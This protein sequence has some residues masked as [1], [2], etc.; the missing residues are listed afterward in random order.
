MAEVTARTFPWLG[1]EV[2]LVLIRPVAGF[3]L[4]S[5]CI[6]GH[7]DVRSLS[8]SHSSLSAA[9]GPHDGSVVL[10]ANLTPARHLTTID[11]GDA[12]DITSRD[13]REGHS[14]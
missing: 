1:D 4:R 13:S 5:K 7:A 11:L 10:Q 9:G 12:K 3:V 6:L 8:R 2:A 14:N